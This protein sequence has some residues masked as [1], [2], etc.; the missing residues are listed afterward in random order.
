MD[1]NKAAKAGIKTP[2]P[3]RETVTFYC[4]SKTMKELRKF[5]SDNKTGYS[6]IIVNL[7]E[8]FLEGVKI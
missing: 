5:A 1:Y 6:P 3:K 4:P 2:K 7:V 8:Q